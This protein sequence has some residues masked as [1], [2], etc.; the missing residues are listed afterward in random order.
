MLNY[1]FRLGKSLSLLLLLVD[2]QLA[3]RQ[4]AVAEQVPAL[5]AVE[6]VSEASGKLCPTNLPQAIEAIANRAEFRYSRW[7]ILIQPLFS[8]TTLYSHDADRYF[9]PA[10][11]VKLLTTAAA[12]YRLGSDFRIRTSVYGADTGADITTLRVIGR[13]DPS[14]S[15]EQLKDLAQQLKSHGIRRVE[16]LI[17]DDSYFSEPTINPSW[18]WEDINAYYGTAVNSSILNQNAALL[19]LSPQQIGR[20]LNVT[21]ADPVAGRQWQLENNTVTSNTSE[22]GSSESVEISGVFGKPLL[23][24]QG[25]LGVDAEPMLTAVA[26]PDPTDYFLQ[27]VRNALAAEEIVVVRASVVSDFNSNGEPELAVVESPTLA[28]LLMETNQQSNN[29]YAEAL[30]RSLGAAQPVAG[31][32]T[33]EAG[34]QQVKAILTELGV[35]PEGYVLADGS[36]L[37]RHNLVS[38]TTLVQTLQ[39]MAKTPVADVYRASLSVSGVSGTL[40][41]RFKN[42]SAQGIVQAKTGTMSGVSTLSGYVKVPGYQPLVFS[43]MVNQSNQPVTTIRQAMDEIVVLLTRLRSC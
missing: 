38:P 9:I 5:T 41:R 43:I 39:A 4:K 34:L 31:E 26:I 20:P 19:T 8:N 24:I 36:G 17:V 10:S 11:N 3:V 28:T 16:Q 27:H 42:T 33:A 2:V 1:L 12:L 35:D 23:R 40:Q 37:S 18:E 15:D 32:S 21:W 25:Q 13:G 7:G 30:L 14:L 29:L 22:T 6:E